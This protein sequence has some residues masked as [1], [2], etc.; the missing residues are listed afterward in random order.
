MLTSD[1]FKASEKS[2][3]PAIVFMTIMYGVGISGFLLKIHP[4]FALLTPFNLMLS[5][6][7]CMAFHG[8]K[9]LKFLSV[10]F[11]IAL[12][13]FSIEAIGVNTG[14][15]FGVYHYGR[16]LGFKLWQTPL[17]ISVNW[18]LTSYCAAMCINQ[19]S[20]EK[21]NLFFKAFLAALMMVGLDI[22]IEPVAMKTDMW[23]WENNTIPLQN[24]LGWFFTA[25][26]LQM[27]LFYTIGHAKNKVAFSVFILQA[28]FFLIL[29]NF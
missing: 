10:C 19:L 12:V 26:P 8:E 7:M 23:M 3:S 13:G 9:N 16:T 6:A 4:D 27:L 22:L 15:I 5:L 14:K 11:F 17:S 21:V 24:Y 2:I 20:S 29:H 1:V 28:L 25:F 18:L